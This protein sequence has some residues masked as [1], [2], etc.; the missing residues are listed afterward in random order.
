ML[1]FAAIGI[2]AFSQP[3]HNITDPERKY[4]EARDYFI[5]GQYALAYP[6]VKELKLEFPENTTSDH[7]YLND[8]ID[9][10]YITCGLKLMHGVAKEDAVQYILAVNNAPRRQLMSFH[11]AHYFFLQN[12][13]ANAIEYFDKAGYENL[14][15]DQIAD[16]KFEKAYSLFNL[17]QFAEAKPLFNEI[18]QLPQHKYYLP[19]N[20]YYGF[21]SY[22]D[23]QFNEALASFRL[24]EN[25]EEYK[26]VVPYY[27]AEI[28]YFQ[29]KKEEALA[30][31]GRVLARPNT[32][33]YD[34]Q[35]KLLTGQI[36]F[37]KQE[38]KKALPLLEDYVN[39][40]PKVSNEVLYEL[41]YSYY[42]ENR[43]EKAIEGF[44]LLS[45]QRDSM[46]QNSM[47]LL[48]DLYLRTRQKANARNAFQSAAFNNSNK[49]QQKVARFNYAK[50]SY[51][52]GY[53]DIA[54]NEMK[55]YLVDYPASEY[56]TEAK[57]ILVNLLANTNNFSDALSIYESFERPT[58]SMQKALPR[59]LYGKAIE[60]INDQQLDRADELLTKVIS[61]PHAA[62][63][64][65][66]AQFWKGEIAYR[67]Q[68][69][70]EAIRL[71]T[72]YLQSSPSPQ[73][74]ANPSAARYDLGYGW[75]YKE[76]Y[77]KAQS[78]FEQVAGNVSVASSAM[79]Q[80]AY[81]R[82]ADALFMQRDFTK[83][84]AMYDKII[85]NALMQS[86][87]AMYQKGMI[88]GIKNSAEKIRVLNTIIRQ[89][90]RSN[91]VQ[92]INMEIA[93]T[94][95]ADEKF[96]DAV[97]YLNN[98]LSSNEGG[99]KPRA[100]LKL[101]LAY[102]NSNKNKEALANYDLLIKKYPQSPE[103]DEA[104]GIIRDIYIEEGRPNDYVEMMRR[105]GKNIS[106]TEADSLTYTAASLRYNSNDCAAAIAG[107]NNYLTRFPDG[108]YAIDANYYKAECFQR[109]KDWKNAVQGYEFVNNK[110]LSKFFEKATLEAARISYFELKDYTNAKKYFE[111][112]RSNAV[113]QD[114]LLEA[115]RGVVRSYYLLKEYQSANDAAKELLTKKGLSTD[116]RS[117]GFLVL[118][119]SQQVANDCNAAILS[120]RS[121]AGINKTAWG[122]E[123]RYEI[124]N[125][126]F[127][128]GNKEA[129]EKAAMAV[130]KETG[131]YD[132]WV[133]KSYILLGDIFMQQKDYFNAK[134][135]YESVSKNAAIPDLQTEARQKLDKAIEEEKQ[136]SKIGN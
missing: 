8:D 10:Y 11:L 44:K 17:K 31:A 1:L 90:P 120:F 25:T 121:A 7:T 83:A 61:N 67:Q 27:I 103:A 109:N 26:D 50:L 9:Y 86:D 126:Y 45:S 12:D 30:Y 112:L 22:Y 98:I 111:S 105:N 68:R 60:Y 54:L 77:G 24:V 74:E 56:D 130:I 78:Y 15:N 125:C 107:F 62:N 16:A 128:L 82:A 115:L 37:E 2:A 129:A 63:I 59:I 49:A 134:A 92:D 57:E 69:Y 85:N 106:V 65:P 95:I 21:I 33:Y 6:I 4:K 29:G 113:S 94:Y 48:G 66:V 123:A 102:Y 116:D 19:A 81:V 52:L 18:H 35:L 13:F 100:Y 136:N 97:P 127:S 75:L 110:G 119:K 99:L 36:Y 46:G 132:N 101:G 117:I 80:D 76:D 47:Y 91:L 38:Y 20:Y 51:E 88:A 114:N 108:V 41:S 70:D 53:Q 135:T 79:E 5:K 34:K 89:Y 14:D 96:M 43:F 84:G 39:N 93:L 124:A 87:Y 122:A 73:G 40:S 71:M 23:R 28:Y 32:L 131:S 42:K 72:V 3:T 58:P 118:G 104:L 133:T 55:K 64:I